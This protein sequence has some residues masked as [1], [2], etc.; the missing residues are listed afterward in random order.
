MFTNCHGVR[1]NRKS[2]LAVKCGNLDIACRIREVYTRLRRVRLAV[3]N[4][5]TFVAI[6]TLAGYTAASCNPASPSAKTPTVVQHSIADIAVLDA[7]TAK[8]DAAAPDAS[9]SLAPQADAATNAAELQQAT[10]GA[11]ADESD[12]PLDPTPA[13]GTIR[14][15]AVPSG[16]RCQVLSDAPKG[17]PIGAAIQSWLDVQDQHASALAYQLCEL[18]IN[19]SPVAVGHACR[20]MVRRPQPA[21]C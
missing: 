3:M 19:L 8:P 21:A 5:A 17:A 7:R 16:A 15:I 1:R 14:N 11:P 4:A 6:V 12:Y 2:A 13:T 18:G 20:L 9:T 10:G